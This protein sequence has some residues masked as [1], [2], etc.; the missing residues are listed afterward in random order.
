MRVQFTG[1][2][3][4]VSDDRQV[5]TKYR[6]GWTGT[7]SKAIGEAAIAAGKANLMVEG[8]PVGPR[9]GKAKAVEPDER[10]PRNLPA[11]LAEPQALTPNLHERDGG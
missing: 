1:D 9:G 11:E 4:H 5:E 10:L 6:A 2:F 7:V 3:D 8:E